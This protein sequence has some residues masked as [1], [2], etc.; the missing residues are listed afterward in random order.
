MK[1]LFNKRLLSALLVSVLL[2]CVF[3]VVAFADEVEGNEP[4]E[5]EMSTDEGTL[6]NDDR[7]Y[8]RCKLPLGYNVDFR[9]TY[10]FANDVYSNGSYLEISSYSRD[11]EIVIVEGSYISDEYFSYY[12][13]DEGRKSIEDFVQGSYTAV[14]LYDNGFTADLDTT[15]LRKLDELY[16]DSNRSVDVTELEDLNRYE[17]MVYD[18][19]DSV[20]HAYGAL[21]EYEGGMWYLNYDKLS[22]EYFDADGNFSYRR[23][24]VTIHEVVDPALRLKILE[25]EENLDYEYSYEYEDGNG[26]G[27]FDG[28]EKV[29]DVLIA[30]IGFWMVLISIGLALPVCML[31]VGIKNSRSAMHG[32]GKHWLIMSLACAVWIVIAIAI[33]LI[34]IL[35]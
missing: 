30:K 28:L 9:C 15:V 18:S 14:R 31:F 26:L 16:I 25:A 4:Y 8:Y 32:K 3:G 12:A 34:I 17:V 24:R 1:K 21:Y 5:W 23:G 29:D 19:T 6:W 11:G 13:T 7:E 22:N 10:Y 2:I 35:G 20:S 27:S 33:A